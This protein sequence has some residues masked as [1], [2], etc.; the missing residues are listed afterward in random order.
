MAWA[1]VKSRELARSGQ[2]D[3][4]IG[5]REEIFHRQSVFIWLCDYSDCVYM[6]A[7]ILGIGHLCMYFVL[8]LC[9]HSPYDLIM[10]S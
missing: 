9:Y 10:S 5:F 1:S 2:G 7:A 6:G 3:G 8:K 4:L